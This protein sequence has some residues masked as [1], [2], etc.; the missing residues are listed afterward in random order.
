MANSTAAQALRA[1]GI[2]SVAGI[3]GGLAGAWIGAAHLAVLASLVFAVVLIAATRD[4]P[5]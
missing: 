5:R 1:I 3:L 4:R 2:A